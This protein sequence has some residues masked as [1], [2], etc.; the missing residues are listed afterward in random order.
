MW[1]FAAGR[2]EFGPAI[3]VGISALNR[4]GR[5]L[6][7][8]RLGWAA[9][10]AIAAKE[11]NFVMRFWKHPRLVVGIGRT[12]ERRIVAHELRRGVA[13][14]CSRL[15]AQQDLASR[16]DAGPRQLSSLSPNNK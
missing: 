1:V 3:G 15:T 11:R 4:G 10:T 2:I 7:A 9:N 8:R 6:A 13:I 16:I 14:L 12:I 5:L